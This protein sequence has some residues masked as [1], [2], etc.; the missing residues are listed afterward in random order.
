MSAKILVLGATGNL[1]SE[2]VRQLL[3]KGHNVRAAVRQPDAYPTAA[4][5]V[6]AVRFDFD[7]PTSYSP[8]LDGIEKLFLLA[9][10]LDPEAAQVLAPV[11]QAAKQAG[12]QQVV[13]NSVLGA[14]QNEAAPLRQVE[15]Q[16]EESGLKYTFL[17]PN[18][19]MENF[20]GGFLAPM[21]EATNGIYVAADDA[22]TSFISTFDIAA[23]AV[24][25]LTEEGHAGQ[26]YNL[27]GNAAIDHYEAAA[28]LS[29]IAD[30]KIAYVPISEA[31]MLAAVLD[32]GM[33]QGSADYLA[34]LYQVTRAGLVSVITDHVQRVLGREPISF[35]EFAQKRLS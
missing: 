31:D 6:E 17:R 13:F 26:A 24:A 9:R 10:P 1:G 14:E 15:R 27:T 7:D 23:V 4:H 33:P 29:E 34:L 30:K 2:V 12:V 3:E 19:F 22:K 16:L 21:I 11:I 25:A 5:K 8:A 28:I 32:N 20:S 35:T 18:F